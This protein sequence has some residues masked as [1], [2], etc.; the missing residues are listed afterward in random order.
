MLSFCEI[1]NAKMS[2]KKYG[3]FHQ[4]FI[5]VKE[6]KFLIMIKLLKLGSQSREFNKFF[7][8]INCFRKISLN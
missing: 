2:R 8:A 5:K 6:E 7:C 1:R 4:T 3:I